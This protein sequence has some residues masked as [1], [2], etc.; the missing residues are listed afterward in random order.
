MVF[1]HVKPVERRIPARMVE[2]VKAEVSARGYRDDG[3]VYCGLQ[4]GPTEDGIDAIVDKSSQ[5]RPQPQSQQ[6]EELERCCYLAPMAHVT[7]HGWPTHWQ[8]RGVKIH[9]WGTLG[10]ARG[11]VRGEVTHHHLDVASVLTLV[12]SSGSGHGSEAEEERGLGMIRLRG[13][14]A[15]R[16]REGGLSVWLW[17][18]VFLPELSLLRTRGLDGCSCQV[19]MALSIC[20]R[21][22]SLMPRGRRVLCMRHETLAMAGGSASRNPRHLPKPRQHIRGAQLAARQADRHEGTG[23]HTCHQAGIT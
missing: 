6:I 1:T 23:V 10:R 2:T 19:R 17:A 8:R 7:M 16:V 12:R 20:R 5:L 11:G 15:G 3:E 18:S 4:G 14:D 21:V 13:W 9:R 22:E